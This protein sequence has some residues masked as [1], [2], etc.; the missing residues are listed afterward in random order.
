MYKF[1]TSFSK[2]LIEL[3]FNQLYINLSDHLVMICL[4]EC[5][6]SS[7]Q[8]L[9]IGQKLVMQLSKDAM[10]LFVLYSTG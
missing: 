10:L 8:N 1:D 4:T 9:K 2:G 7:L 3:F 5:A 6:F